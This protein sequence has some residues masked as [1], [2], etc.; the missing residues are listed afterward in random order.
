MDEQA[1]DTN[2]HYTSLTDDRFGL[3]VSFT[4]FS[5]HFFFSRGKNYNLYGNVFVIFLE[6]K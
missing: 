4:S 1:S 3:Q 2:G 5:F 6:K